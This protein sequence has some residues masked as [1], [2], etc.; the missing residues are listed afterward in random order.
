MAGTESIVSTGK[1]RLDGRV[2]LVTGAARGLGRT[3]AQALAR[4]GASVAFADLENAEL[5]AAEVAGEPG[6]GKV[7]GLA[8]DITR[9]GDCA[10][11][12]A[13]TLA[14][15]GALHILVNNAGKGPVHV[16][17]SPRTKSLKFWEADPD[18]WQQVIVTN[19]NGT[20][21]MSRE[22]APAMIGAGWGRIINI[23][24][25]LATMQR[26]QNSPYGVSKAAIEAETLIW[27]KD[28][29][30][31]GV[32]VNSLIPGGAVDTDFVSAAMRH[33]GR[34]LLQ[35]PV[36]IAP[37]LW[38]ASTASDGVTGSRFVGKNWDGHLPP[39]AAARAALEA[40]VLLPAPDGR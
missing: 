21:L 35:P 5:A 36:M 3:M 8:C 18:I 7:L 28:L 34:P 38:L 10:H 15:F 29:E 20:F 12:V 32:T 13:A 1:T 37:L 6:C 4:A 11:A 27:A 16:E 19:V 39:E 26:R 14:A 2:A 22:A 31:T 25:S 40:P 17:A 9:Q 23:T 24:T 33:S 30:G